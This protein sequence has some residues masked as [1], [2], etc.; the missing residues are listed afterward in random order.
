MLL[1]RPEIIQIRTVSADRSFL[2]RLLQSSWQR[3]PP[4]QDRKKL[5]QQ[6]DAWLP[7]LAGFIRVTP[8]EADARNRPGY[9][10]KEDAPP[11]DAGNQHASDHRAGRHPRRRPR[12]LYAYR[13]ITVRIPGESVMDERERA[14]HE[15]RR[16]HAL[17]GSRPDQERDTD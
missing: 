13:F 17:K 2:T 1:P 10:D 14:G 16:T 4:G 3:C 15:N 6:V 12:S 5:A 11:T 9:V 7:R 8:N